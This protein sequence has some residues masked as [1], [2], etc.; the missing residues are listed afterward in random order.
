L[1]SAGMSF[2]KKLH[3]KLYSLNRNPF[4]DFGFFFW[5]CYGTM[6]IIFNKRRRRYFPVGCRIKIL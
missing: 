3:A 6:L 1:K 5:F 4:V 2:R